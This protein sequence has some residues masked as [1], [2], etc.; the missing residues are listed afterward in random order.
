[1]FEIYREVASNASIRIGQVW[2]GPGE[3]EVALPADLQFL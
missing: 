2:P 3:M 1:M